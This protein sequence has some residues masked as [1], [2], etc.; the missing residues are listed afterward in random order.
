M[1]MISLTLKFVITREHPY[2]KFI[3]ITL[4]HKSI[5]FA[6]K[7]RRDTTTTR[8]GDHAIKKEANGMVV[9]ITLSKRKKATPN[10]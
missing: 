10:Y 9:T 1:I 8:H 3:M 7:Q 5:K 2:D 4:D 6:R